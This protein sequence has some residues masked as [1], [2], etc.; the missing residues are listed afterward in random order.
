MTAGGAARRGPVTP[1]WRTADWTYIR[2]HTGRATPSPCY[3]ERALETWATRIADGWGREADGYVYF[4]NDHQGC[5]LRDAGMF[6][7]L[8]A[9]HQ[10]Q[11]GGR[12]EP[13]DPVLAA[14]ADGHPRTGVMGL[15]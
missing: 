7:R 11:T 5:A 6:A 10:V 2:F 12:P 9:L 15:Q 4:N 13:G 8:L 1:I 3:G 14:A